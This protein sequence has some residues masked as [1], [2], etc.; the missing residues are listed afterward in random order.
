MPTHR[1]T[2]IPADALKEIES[3]AGP[4][5]H[6]KMLS[7]G[8]N[9]EIAAR[10][11]FT[12]GTVFVKGLRQDHPR[13]WTQQREAD[14]NPHTDGLAPALRWH[15]HKAG[16]NL[17][18]FED[19]DGRHADYSPG[20]PDVELVL[21]ALWRLA[22]LG[23]PSSVDLKSMPARMSGHVEDP[24]ETDLFAGSHLLHTDWNPHN[25][26]I[27]DGTARLVDWAWA[28]RGAS[29]IDP[30]LWVIWLIA[31]GHSVNS[32][33]SLAGQHPAWDNTPV[34]SIDAF[35]QAQRRLWQTIASADQP[36]EWTHKLHAAA[37][38]WAEQRQ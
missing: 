2:E 19:L 33:E 14:I 6:I 8:Y 37:R 30:A 32:A 10:L 23:A 31:S 22:A 25:V 35:A 12:N 3:V 1:L 17:L 20:S 4:V 16:W 21:Q 34:R 15:I 26:L 11:H 13:V 29:W 9:S 27:A 18:G 36:D 38:A 5:L 28:S 7:A 24:D